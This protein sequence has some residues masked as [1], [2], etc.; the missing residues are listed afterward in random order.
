MSIMSVTTA[1]IFHPTTWRC[2]SKPWGQPKEAHQA[3]SSRFLST[4]SARGYWGASPK[5]LQSC[6]LWQKT[7]S[8]YTSCMV[9]ESCDHS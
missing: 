6:A 5:L 8:R 9:L 7:C 4:T 3:S 1:Y 2:L